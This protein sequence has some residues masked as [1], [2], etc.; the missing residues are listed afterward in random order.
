MTR[1][2]ALS[3]RKVAAALERAGLVHVRTK[4]SHIAT[5]IRLIGDGRQSCRFTSGIFRRERFA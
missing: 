1:L 5:S 4:G 2:P 3:A